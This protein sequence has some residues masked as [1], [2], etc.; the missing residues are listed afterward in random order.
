MVAYGKK[1]RKSNDL[2]TRESFADIAA[3]ILEYFDVKQQ[4][5]GKSFLRDITHE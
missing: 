3:T 5:E 2:G 4:V 1:I